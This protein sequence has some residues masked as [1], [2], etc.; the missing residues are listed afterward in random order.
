MIKHS[1][2]D[3]IIDMALPL[4]SAHGFKATGIDKIIAASGVAKASFYRHFPSKDDLVLACL[5]VWHTTHFEALTTHTLTA[6]EKGRPVAIFEALSSLCDAPDFRGC[7]L[8]NALMETPDPSHPV[9]I[10]VVNAK[11]EIRQW[12][13][14]VLAE[15]GY[16]D[17]NDTLSYEWLVLYDGA[18]IMAMRQPGQ[19]SGRRAKSSAERSLQQIQLK[20]LLSKTLPQ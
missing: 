17:L 16:S 14:H 6:D 10:Y 9:H 19:T 18:M 5:K 2:K 1:V 15:A 12:F 13:E 3:R 4:F 7:L 8:N 20:R 11:E